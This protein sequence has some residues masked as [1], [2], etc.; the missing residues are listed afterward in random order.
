MNYIGDHSL[1]LVGKV[2]AV[3]S[4]SS[5]LGATICR[6]L[7]NSNALVMGVNSTAAHSSTVASIGSHFQFWEYDAEKGPNGEQ[8]IM[9]KVKRAYLK[10]D[11]DFLVVVS[12]G[13]KGELGIEGLPEVVD[14][15]KGQREG[16]VLS[17]SG[18]NGSSEKQV[19]GERRILGGARE[20]YYQPC[21]VSV[22]EV[23]KGD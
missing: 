9:E 15:M 10:G 1:N 8:E 20:K 23:G 16:L 19:D 11:V 7:L 6:S 13:K 4:A 21:L 12:E 3:T 22:Y 2:A 5:T 17:V 18:G 14:A